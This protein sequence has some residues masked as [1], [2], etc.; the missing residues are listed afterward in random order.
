MQA[1]REKRQGHPHMV[2]TSVR[3]WK[4]TKKDEE[5]ERTVDLETVSLG[6]Q[7]FTDVF[8]S[9][10]NINFTDLFVFQR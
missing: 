2:Q 10:A 5:K 9:G 1:V 4:E 7:C 8:K 6:E 3:R